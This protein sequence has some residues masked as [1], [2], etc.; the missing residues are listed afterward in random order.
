MSHQSNLNPNQSLE[1]AA[2]SAVD[3]ISSQ[4]QQQQ[5]SN[6]LIKKFSL[7]DTTQSKQVVDSVIEVLDLAFAID[8]Q[9]PDNEKSSNSDAFDSSIFYTALNFDPHNF[10]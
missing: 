4:Q 1:S 8:Q 7:F 3:Q 2:N 5:Q 9:Q 10:K 6:H